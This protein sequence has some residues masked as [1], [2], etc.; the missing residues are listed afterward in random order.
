MNPKDGKKR[1]SGEGATAASASLDR[2]LRPY[3]FALGFVTKYCSPPGAGALDFL[4]RYFGARFSSTESARPGVERLYRKNAKDARRSVERTGMNVSVAL[5]ITRHIL[6]SYTNLTQLSPARE[7][8]TVSKE[9][10]L[11][12]KRLEMT[13]PAAHSLVP[14]QRGARVTTELKELLTVHERAAREIFRKVES[15][16]ERDAF[17]GPPA[18]PAPL[19]RYFQPGQPAVSSTHVVGAP[20]L[21]QAKRTTAAHGARPDHTATRD[22]IT[23]AYVLPRSSVSILSKADLMTRL[24]ETTEYREKRLRLERPESIL[25][26]TSSQ[27]RRTRLAPAGKQFRA[28]LEAHRSGGNRPEFVRRIVSVPHSLYEPTVVKA[29]SASAT[30]RLLDFRPS[31]TPPPGA[32]LRLKAGVTKAGV[33]GQ[34]L[35]KPRA[36]KGAVMA[37]LLQETRLELPPVARVFAS[38]PQPPVLEASQVVRQIEEKEMIETIRREVT[39]QMKSQ[40]AADNFTRADFTIITDQVYDALARRLLTERERLGLSS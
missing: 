16:R 1:K 26:I 20:L 30:G 38:R 10:L 32:A 36:G 3:R 40:R 17:P 21:S 31:L 28:G 19:V 34:L 35:L 6:A 8:A 5:N 25:F 33:G 37:G 24:S 27:G 11:R 15:I 29:G 13:A 4:S 7:A 9:V 2:S 39:T 18:Q 23:G 22:S 14:V 12:E